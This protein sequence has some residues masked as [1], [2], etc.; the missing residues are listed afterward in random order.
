MTVL[1]AFSRNPQEML[2]GRP[3][4]PSDGLAAL[5]AAGEAGSGKRPAAWV[6]RRDLPAL[7]GARSASW[8]Q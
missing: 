2:S 8:L 6:T 4:R 7:A 5:A 1:D 3:G